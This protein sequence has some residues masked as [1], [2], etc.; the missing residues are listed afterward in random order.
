LRPNADLLVSQ[1]AAYGRLQGHIETHAYYLS[2][3]QNRDILYEEAVLSWYDNVYSPLVAV[4]QEHGLLKA[5]PN[6]TL[7]DLYLFV[8]DYQ[9][10]LRET[11]FEDEAQ[12]E[13]S[14]KMAELYNKKEVRLVLKSLRRANWI[15]QMLLEQERAEFLS[16]TLLDTIRPQADIHLSLPGKYDNLLAHIYAHHY[17]LGL[18]LQADVPFSEA[19]ASFYDNIYVP[20]LALI[21]DQG[22]INDFQPRRTEADLVLWVLDHRQDL[23]QALDSLPTPS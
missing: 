19:V 15:S 9:W 11:D 8:S 3:E 20:L 16:K 2:H 22:T 1:P 12:S 18:S 23:V 14:G 6:Y 5:L 21:D 10:L 17:Y 13:V 4:I 7:T